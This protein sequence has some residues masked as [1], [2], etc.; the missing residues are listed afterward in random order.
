MAPRSRI[1]GWLK[2]DVILTGLAV[3]VV[4][5]LI[6]V[7]SFTFIFARG[8][9]YLVDDP[10]ACINCHAMEDQYRGWVAGSHSHAATCND[11]HT[12][13][14]NLIHKYWTKAENGF[15]HGLMFTTDLYPE[16]IQIRETNERVTNDACLYCHADVTAD[17]RAVAG[18]EQV[19]CIACHADVGHK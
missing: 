14:D 12:P 9:S 16:N 10:A 17:M 2:P 8:Y 1:R 13:H 5:S 19:S 18:S 11:C 7:G 3:F 6:G 15:W 4:G